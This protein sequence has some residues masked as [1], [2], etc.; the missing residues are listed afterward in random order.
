MR[1]GDESADGLIAGINVT[2]LVDIVLVLL[3]VLMVAVPVLQGRAIPMELPDAVHADAEPPPTLVVSIDAARRLHVDGEPVTWP[4]LREAAHRLWAEGGPDASAV[5]AADRA[6]PHGAFVRV[7]D[8]LRGAG[9][10][11]YSLQVEPE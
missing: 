2:P 6:V 4:E 10:D 3:V 5:I 7:I 9:I 8:V 1:A 11:R